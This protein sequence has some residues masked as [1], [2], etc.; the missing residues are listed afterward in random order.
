[1]LPI[2]H[3]CACCGYEAD[4]VAIT[5]PLAPEYFCSECSWYDGTFYESEEDGIREYVAI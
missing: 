5:P 2:I 1:M 4:V 3:P